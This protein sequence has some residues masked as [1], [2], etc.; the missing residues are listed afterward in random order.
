MSLYNVQTKAITVR[1]Y[2]FL[3]MDEKMIAFFNCNSVAIF[4][5]TDN[6]VQYLF[7]VFTSYTGCP[8]K[9][10]MPDSGVHQYFNYSFRE[11]FISQHGPEWH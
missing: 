5:Y 1:D 11:W 4:T 8:R 3:E 10:E 7:H 2:W 9:F 6:L